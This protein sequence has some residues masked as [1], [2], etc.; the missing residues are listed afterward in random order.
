MLRPGTLALFSLALLGLPA[1]PASHA[2]PNCVIVPYGDGSGF[3]HLHDHPGRGV[4]EGPGRALVATTGSVHVLVILAEFSN[5]PA[6]VPAGRFVDH[7]FGDGFTLSSFYAENSRG[8]LTVTGDVHG[9]VTLPQTQFYYAGGTNG[10]G[11]GAYPTNGQGMVE[12]AVQAAVDTGLDLG[13]YDANGDG[14]VDALIVVHS[15]QG[16]EWSASSFSGEPGV[17]TIN[18]HRW[19]VRNGEFGQGAR[20]S[21]YITCPELQI[22]NLGQF[23]AWTDSIAT[24]GV[25]CHEFGHL[26]GLPDF[27]DTET[28]LRRVGVWDVMDAGTWNS[29][30]GDPGLALPGALPSNFSAW[31]RMFLGWETPHE[32]SPSPGETL[33]ET[34][35]LGAISAG[36]SAAQFRSNPAGVDWT[37]SAPGAGEFFLAE[38]RQR[39]GWDAGLP[40]SGVL[41]YHVDESAASNRESAHA[42]G[43]G[44]L[45]LEPADG[46]A[47]S[48]SAGDAW[49]GVAAGFDDDS[50][51]GSRL[52]DGSTSGVSL[53]GIGPLLGGTTTAQAEVV[54]L[55]TPLPVPYAIPN[56]WLPARGPALSIQLAIGTSVGSAVEVEIF[57]LH[58]RRLR[59]LTASALDS[60]QRVATWDGRTDRGLPLPAGMYFFRAKNG[61]GG[62]GRVLLLR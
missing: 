57:D 12:D 22:R 2:G 7:L 23:P 45:L 8:Q 24:I 10:G 28:F 4:A 48:N 40:T 31:S 42:E 30:S 47:T 61:A 56:P 58:G 46:N 1:A 35:T 53:T 49:P 17:D 16:Y 21:D 15:G 52:Y 60:S 34:V 20:I 18:S 55:A 26:L 19:V 51:P 27:Y 25:Y 33:Q 13:D 59:T 5:V 50:F 44:L 29:L 43:G 32:V 6:R 14:E 11:I 3:R 36:G 62:S 54:S 38:A 41:I 39:S 9:W 37:P